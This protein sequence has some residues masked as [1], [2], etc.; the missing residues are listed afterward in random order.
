M[1]YHILNGKSTYL[2]VLATG[3]FFNKVDLGLNDSL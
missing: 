2:S 3:K 1:E